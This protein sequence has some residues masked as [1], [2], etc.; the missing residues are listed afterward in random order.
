MLYYAHMQPQTP[1]ERNYW[2]PNEGPIGGQASSAQSV[3]PA[4]VPSPPPAPVPPQ[5]TPSA[6]D[7]YQPQAF[8]PPSPTPP[9]LDS[10]V[11]QEDVADEAQ[12]VL[13]STPVLQWTAPEF[14]Q[15]EKGAIWFIVLGVIGLLL[16]GVS[17]FLLKDWFFAFILIILL[18]GI[19]SVAVRRPR[20]LHCM[21]DENGIH[22]GSTLYPF[23]KFHAFSLAKEDTAW[24][25]ILIPNARFSPTLTVYFNE[26]QG[27]D[28]V[29]F[30]GDFLP[31]EDHE[32]DL[33]DR[34][35]RKI[36]F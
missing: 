4:P 20:M 18:G 35:S 21:L 31:M 29:D 12:P 1:G 32:V 3:P 10:M 17:I 36:R 33:V 13:P 7:S 8:T 26:E 9:S 22:V 28:I 34:L 6:P 30:L 11:G 16:L 5:P 19:A 2:Q 15:H 24:C 23:E 27:E 14:I 25:I